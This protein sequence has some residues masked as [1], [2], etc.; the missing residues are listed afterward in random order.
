MKQIL[1]TELKRA[2]RGKGMLLSILIGSIVGIA[3]I[4]QYIIPA[5]QANLTHFYENFPIL[6]PNSSLETWIAGSPLNLEGFIFFLILPI[7]ACLPFGTSYFDDRDSGFIKNIYMRTDRKKYL[8]A[9]YI[10]AFFSGGIAVIIPLL[11]NLICSLVMLP[12]LLP[13]STM[14]QNGIT[15]LM[16]F[17]KLFFSYPMIYTI[18]F[19]FIDFLM[20][21]IWSC[22]GLAASFLSDY[23][24]IVLIFPF[25][26]Q[27]I[28]HVICTILNQIGYSSVYWM[29]PG[30]GITE[31][32][33]PV[34]YLMAGV[35]VTLLVFMKKGENEDVF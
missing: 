10:S 1:K 13:I 29:Q 25:F 19:L 3:H 33:I 11:L 23:K 28:F 6:S 8:M 20:A 17:Y 35:I 4:I 31:W 2:M 16:L 30:Y 26:V 22:V 7:L 34:L 32:W 14:G 5:Y 12:N 9:K 21:G 15:P 27:L 24:I 18:L